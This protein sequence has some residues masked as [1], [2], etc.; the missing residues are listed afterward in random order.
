LYSSIIDQLASR[1]IATSV[2]VRDQRHL[3]ELIAEYML[4]HRDDYAPFIDETDVESGAANDGQQ[5]DSFK[6]YCDRIATTSNWGGQLEVCIRRSRTFLNWKSNHRSLSSLSLC[7]CS[8]AFIDAS[9]G[10]SAG[11]FDTHSLGESRSD[12]DG[13]QRDTR[14]RSELSSRRVCARRALQFAEAVADELTRIDL[15]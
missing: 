4:K 3:R 9:S 14:A 2:A 13:R 7:V 5:H 11:L 6:V 10:K 8:L 12:D 15:Y 1:S